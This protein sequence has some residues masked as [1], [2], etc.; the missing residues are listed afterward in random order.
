MNWKHRTFVLAAVLAISST[1]IAREPAAQKAADFLDHPAFCNQL[2]NGTE[3]D[4]D[5]LTKGYAESLL[6]DIN[7]TDFGSENEAFSKIGEWCARKI[8]D[9]QEDSYVKF[10]KEVEEDFGNSVSVNS[11]QNQNDQ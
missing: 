7:A 5:G 10:S 6:Q 9:Q 11:P 8:A 4:V 1:C 2:I 3:S